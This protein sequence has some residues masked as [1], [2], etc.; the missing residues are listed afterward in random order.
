MFDTLEL[1]N[2][3]AFKEAKFDFTNGINVFIGE[4]GTG[5]THVMKLLYCLQQQGGNKDLL[6]KKIANVFRPA[7]GD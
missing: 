7:K 4:N 1:E 5:K 3:G 6:Y 2:F